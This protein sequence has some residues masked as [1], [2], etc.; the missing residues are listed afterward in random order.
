M[1]NS[2][3]WM[4]VS[5]SPGFV[6]FLI[7]NF[8][9]WFHGINVT[10]AVLQLVANTLVVIVWRKAFVDSVGFKKFIAFFGIVVPIVLASVTIYRVL[11]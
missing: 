2:S 11:L 1:K 6:L 3:F 4:V 8:T 7:A 9:S 5:A 10:A